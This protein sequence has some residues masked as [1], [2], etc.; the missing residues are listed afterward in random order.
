M[1]ERRIPEWVRHAPAPS[2][3]DFGILAGLEAVVRGILISVF[4]L[5]LY[6]ALQDAAQVSFLY[7]LV[8]IASLS[9]GL[10]V[11]FAIRFIP[12]RARPLSLPC[13]LFADSTRRRSTAGR[14][15]CRRTP[16]STAT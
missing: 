14:C 5:V 11:P 1:H 6:R 12:R 16:A 8:G 13:D 3:R 7:F 10:M 15:R 9:A 2:V 4:P